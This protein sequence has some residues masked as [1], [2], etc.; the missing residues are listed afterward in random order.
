MI[1]ELKIRFDVPKEGMEMLEGA[2][3]LLENPVRDKAYSYPFSTDCI[4]MLGGV[5]DQL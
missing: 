5:N 2:V 4:F 3:V 1:N